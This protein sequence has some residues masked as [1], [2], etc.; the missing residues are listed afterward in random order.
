LARYLGD[1]PLQAFG[2]PASHPA[3]VTPLTQEQ[4]RPLMDEAV[5]RWSATGADPALLRSV[6][7]QVGDLSG[8]YLG[9]TAGTTIT[10]VRDAAGWGWF[11]DPTPHDDSEFA[12]P[13]D[14]GEQGRMDLL[15]ALMHEMGHALGLD[16]DAGG[17]MQ[18]TLAPGVREAPATHPA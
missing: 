1:S 9:L 13:G 14:Q 4:V 7:V 5:A 11:V 10:L 16:H 18:E 8:A 6:R 17:V 3:S 2:G 15:T 12:T